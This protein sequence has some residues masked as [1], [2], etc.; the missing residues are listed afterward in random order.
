MLRKAQT[1]MVLV[2]LVV[3]I[4]GCHTSHEVKLDMHLYIHHIEGEVQQQGTRSL[5]DTQEG[6]ISVE[7]DEMAQ[8]V[9]QDRR[10]RH[11]KIAYYQ[12]KGVLGENAQ[13]LL[14]IRPKT[15]DTMMEKEQAQVKELMQAENADRKTLQDYVAKSQELDPGE[16][17]MVQYEWAAT[18][19]NTLPQGA[20]F[21]VPTLPQYYE[22]FM[23]SDLGRAFN[24][25][26]EKGEWKQNPLGAGS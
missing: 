22:D 19:R 11:S 25:S 13:G 3:G 15:F 16:A 14:E 9:L 23:K 17:S 21:Q 26:P 12:E 8:K 10:S 6:D 2:L 5:A 20:W 18:L 1:L 24:E 7:L 4:S